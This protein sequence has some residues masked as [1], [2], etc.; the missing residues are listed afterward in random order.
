MTT[1]DTL[2]IVASIGYQKNW[3]QSLPPW[4]YFSE[5]Y[6]SDYRTHAAG[7]Q[8]RHRSGISL[9]QFFAWQESLVV[10]ERASVER[11]EQAGIFANVT[12]GDV[13]EAARRAVESQRVVMRPGL[14]SLLDN[15]Q[16]QG[17]RVTVVSVNWSSRFIRSCLRSFQG[18]QHGKASG[19]VHIRANDI[20]L[21]SNG[22]LSRTFEKENRGI[23]TA[24]DK[25]RVMREGVKAGPGQQLSVYVGDSL[26][27]LPCLL[28][29]DVGVCIRDEQSGSEQQ[30]LRE[31]Q[32]KLD[33]SCQ[34]I[35]EYIPARN[36]GLDRK[37]RNLWWA[38][39]FQE[40][41][42]S[43]LVLQGAI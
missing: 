29:A 18:P 23:W 39:D 25:A 26:T 5:A 11:V 41:C 12:E 20:K 3:S 8:A 9:E 31:T 42:T 37:D 19:E 33:I 13:D 22:R 24:G 40:I 14:I 4:S 10:V 35:G 2:S 21:G 43:N 32:A 17:N 7:D 16:A 15:L 34:W 38:R 1:S 28:L 30:S 6:I 27:D 36:G